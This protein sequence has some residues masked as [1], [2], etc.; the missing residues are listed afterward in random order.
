MNENQN[1]VQQKQERRYKLLIEL[2][3]AAEGKEYIKIDFLRVAGKA[4]FDEQ[5][6]REIYNYFNGENFFKHQTVIGLNVMLSHKAITEIE[7]S[8]AHPQKS[9]EHFS[10]TVIQN[11]HAPVGAVHTGNN[12]VSNINQNIG[13]NFS[14]I[15]EQLAILKNQFQSSQVVDKDEAIEI[16]N[17]LEKEIVKENPSKRKIISFLSST[18]DFAVKTGTEL[19]ASTLAKLL[20]SQIG[21]KG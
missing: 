12:N 6:A 5:E 19:A 18:K 4:G 13:Q 1:I 21:I 20:E 9:T 14:E 3:K 10:S 17:D 7:N 2:W 11:F 8:I 16:I 15:L